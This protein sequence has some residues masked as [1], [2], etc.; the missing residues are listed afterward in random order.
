MHK[1]RGGIIAALA[2]LLLAI[3]CGSWDRDRVLALEEVEGVYFSGG[4]EDRWAFP[5]WQ[6]IRNADSVRA[7]CA[8]YN[9]GHF[10]RVRVVLVSTETTG[11]GVLDGVDRLYIH[12]PRGRVLTGSRIRHNYPALQRKLCPAI[13]DWGT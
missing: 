6:K 13:K 12:V 11:A 8:Y 10:S 9:P 5:K 2:I 3:G 4:V 1:A 7:E